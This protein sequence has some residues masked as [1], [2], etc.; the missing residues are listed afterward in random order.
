MAHQACGGTVEQ[1]LR[2]FDFRQQRGN[3]GLSCSQFSPGQ[4]CA[5]RLGLQMAHG[6]PRRHQFM[7]G[8]QWRWQGGRGQLRKLLPGL[9]Q[10]ADQQ[11]ATDL[12]IAR[13]GGVHPII[14][15][16]QGES[17]RLEGLDRPAEVP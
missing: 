7:G 12:Q 1:V 3:A 6:D 15:S 9:V 13:M 14:V 17:R 2:A 10:L 4:G 8:P 16:I 11:Q 5:R